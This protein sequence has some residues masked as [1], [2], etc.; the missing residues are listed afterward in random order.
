MGTYLCIQSNRGPPR[1]MCRAKVGVRQAV[2][3]VTV[4]VIL[5]EVNIM[6]KV[7]SSEVM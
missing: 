3:V 4:G 5:Q 7:M 2:V 6:S 1:I